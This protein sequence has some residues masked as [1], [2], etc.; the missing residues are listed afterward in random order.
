MAV[1]R[2]LRGVPIFPSP[3][4]MK[5]LS[6]TRFIQ[7][8]LPFTRSSIPAVGILKQKKK[9]IDR[10]RK[11]EN[12]TLFVFDFFVRGSNRDIVTHLYFLCIISFRFVLFLSF[13]SV[14]FRVLSYRVGSFRF[15]RFVPFRFV[16]FL[17]FRIVSFFFIY[18]FF[19]FMSSNA[20]IFNLKQSS[21]SFWSWWVLS[22]YFEAT[23]SI[24]LTWYSLLVAWCN[25]G[26]FLGN[27]TEFYHRS[28]EG[29]G[30]Q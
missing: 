29:S 17:S 6:E 18:I 11:I 5:K 9:P 14:P 10:M 21:F 12:L 4:A 26:C 27:E 19:V 20:A 25:K 2:T 24:N 23:F 7:W 30:S 13:S 15:F 1:K 16:S 22:R 28:L 3:E 8:Y